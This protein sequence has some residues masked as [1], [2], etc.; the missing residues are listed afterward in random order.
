MKRLGSTCVWDPRAFGIHVQRSR[1]SLLPPHA[2]RDGLRGGVCVCVCVWGRRDG[3]PF[4]APGG[5]ECGL[6][7]SLLLPEE[8][9]PVLGAERGSVWAVGLVRSQSGPTCAVAGCGGKGGSEQSTELPLPSCGPRRAAAAAPCAAASL[10]RSGAAGVPLGPPGCGGGGRGG[11][12][13]RLW[14]RLRSRSLASGPRPRSRG[15]QQHSC[16]GSRRRSY[17]G[18]GQRA[19]GPGAAG[20]A[21]GRVGRARRGSLAS[22]S[23]VCCG[24]EPW[25]HMPLSLCPGKVTPPHLQSHSHTPPFARAPPPGPR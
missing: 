13:G 6:P 8:V 15:C 19:G 14:G 17:S 9:S 18:G 1:P 16:Q 20:D 25:A 10:P 4:H 11:C 12:G 23:V 7:L 3:D 2:G 5:V 22:L 24:A 21:L